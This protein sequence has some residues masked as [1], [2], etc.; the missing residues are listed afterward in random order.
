MKHPIFE[1]R[2]RLLLGPAVHSK[3]QQRLNLILRIVAG[4]PVIYEDTPGGP[5]TKGLMD[6]NFPHLTPLST[7]HTH[8]HN[9]Y[10]QW[11]L[12]QL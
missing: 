2:Q 5:E 3:S 4:K 1:V 6:V 12:L 7:T 9:S 8:K 10:F 11:Q